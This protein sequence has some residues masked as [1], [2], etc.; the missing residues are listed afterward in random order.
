MKV[1]SR[2][3]DAK[4]DRDLFAIA[5]KTM[6]RDGNVFLSPKPRRDGTIIPV[7]SRPAPSRPVSCYY[8]SVIPRQALN[9]FVG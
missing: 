1:F 4:L 2:Q 3:K 6:K 7:P 5:E 9:I 8:P